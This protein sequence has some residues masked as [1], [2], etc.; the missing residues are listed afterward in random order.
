MH[1]AV[2][3]Q[4]RAIGRN[5]AKEACRSEGCSR[6]GIP[7]T[8][9]QVHQARPYGRL[10][11]VRFGFGPRW[12]RSFEEDPWRMMNRQ[13]RHMEKFMDEMAAPLCRH[14]NGPWWDH[15]P[16]RAERMSCKGAAE[17]EAMKLNEKEFEI[18]VNVSAYKPEDLEVKVTSD[19]LT[20]AGKHEDKSDEFG[21]VSR[22]FTRH[23]AIPEA[24]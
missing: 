11:P 10:L 9:D 1:R 19:K 5:V 24:S 6:K 17:V 3:K 15:G 13:R 4:C 2:G 23:F 21:I 8:L 16:I 22:E 12:M 20:V 18:K 14:G 7:L